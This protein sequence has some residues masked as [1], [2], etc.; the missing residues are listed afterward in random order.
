MAHSVL[1]THLWEPITGLA[2]EIES[3]RALD[4][5]VIIW[6]HGRRE[7]VNRTFSQN[8]L[9]GLFSNDQ[10]YD[11]QS[12]LK[13]GIAIGRKDKGPE[14][15][16]RLFAQYGVLPENVALLDDTKRNHKSAAQAGLG[17]RAW[18]DW[19]EIDKNK[20]I[21]FPKVKADNTLEG[22]KHIKSFLAQRNMELGNR[23]EPAN[24][25]HTK[26]PHVL[27]VK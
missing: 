25:N 3:L 10:I 18:V 13:D 19:H 21:D 27:S 5:E 22:I 7:M 17:C 1:P 23:S 16:A 20:V 11:K 2:K 6:T 4:A 14:N 26:S 8:G 15:Y 9:V 12:L 24:L